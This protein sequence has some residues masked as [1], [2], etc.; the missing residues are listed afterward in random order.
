MKTFKVNN[1][2]AER[3][4]LGSIQVN[5]YLVYEENAKEAILIDPGSKSEELVERINE[6]NFD[7]ITIF[8]THGHGDHIAG[9]E[10]FRRHFPFI[11]LAVSIEDAYM[12]SNPEENLSVYID[13][14]VTIREAE[15][16]IKEGDTFKTGSHIGVARHIP[17]HTKGGMALIFDEIV[18]SGDTLFHESV[19]RTDFP[20][21]DSEQLIKSIE[22]KLL[23][24]SDRL[25]LPGHGRETSIKHEIDDNPFVSG[26]SF[27]AEYRV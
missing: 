22:S 13:E 6:L 16:T 3:Y 25:V 10:Y 5:T 27:C 1:L 23:N 20:G 9:V 2:V 15:I 8:L 24:L 17:G 19:G 26:D 11:K 21:G 4:M 14:A 7:K 18:F 12:L